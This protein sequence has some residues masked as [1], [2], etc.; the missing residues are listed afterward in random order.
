M[1]W[2]TDHRRPAHTFDKAD[3]LVG[4][5]L[6]V[7]SAN[8][9]AIE[10][11]IN[12]PTSHPPTQSN[13]QVFDLAHS[14]TDAPRFHFNTEGQRMGIILVQAP[15]SCFPL[16]ASRDNQFASIHPFASALREAQLSIQT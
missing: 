2:N 5:V 11:C 10:T 15:G 7:H 13:T 16:P 8:V 14:S 3:C 9:G 1:V 12:L 4:A 6:L